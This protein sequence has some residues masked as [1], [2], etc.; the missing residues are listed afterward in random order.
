LR[1]LEIAEPDA[2]IVK[3]EVGKFDIRAIARSRASLQLV[4]LFEPY[5]AFSEQTNR[6]MAP[7]SPEA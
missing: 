6:Q 4:K 5:I 3:Q 7:L 2:L 1:V